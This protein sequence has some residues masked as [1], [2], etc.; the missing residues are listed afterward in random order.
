M[1]EKAS[2]VEPNAK[3]LFWDTAGG[4]STDPAT[5]YFSITS[6]EISLGY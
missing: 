4:G 5:E 2:G 3:L 6:T 1:T